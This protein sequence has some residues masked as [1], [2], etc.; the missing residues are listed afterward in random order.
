MK[1]IFLTSVMTL[2]LMF[3]AQAQRQMEYLNRGIYAVNEGNGK[4]FVSWRLMENEPA[5]VGF[6]LYRTS[7]GKTVKLNGSPLLKGTDFVDETVD[8]IAVA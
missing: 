8:T 4:V 2:S 1:K 6:N 7:N 3:A 5:D